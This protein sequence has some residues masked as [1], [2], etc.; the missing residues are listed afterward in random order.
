LVRL[1]RE[2][3]NFTDTQ[4]VEIRATIWEAEVSR[5]GRKKYYVTEHRHVRTDDEADRES[6]GA[7]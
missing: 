7:E 4:H 2:A 3:L 6:V 5:S 1:M